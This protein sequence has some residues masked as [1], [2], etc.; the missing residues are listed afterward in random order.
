MPDVTAESLHAL[1]EE[2]IEE[3]VEGLREKLLGLENFAA[4]RYVSSVHLSINEV[5]RFYEDGD[6]VRHDKLTQLCEQLAVFFNDPTTQIPPEQRHQLEAYYSEKNTASPGAMPRELPPLPPLPNLAS[7]PP[8]ANAAEIRQANE[9]A[10]HNVSGGGGGALIPDLNSDDIADGVHDMLA[11][12]D[13]EALSDFEDEV[14]PTRDPAPTP[15]T[16]ATPAPP[17]PEPTPPPTQSSP[18]PELPSGPVTH[19]SVVTMEEE[20]EE[21]KE[22]EEEQ[23]K[24]K[25]KEK[26][27]ESETP[28]RAP[29]PPSSVTEEPVQ[30]MEGAPV[31][32]V[33]EEEDDYKRVFNVPQ[34]QPS[35]TA[36]ADAGAVPL[37]R[38]EPAAGEDIEEISMVSLPGAV[39][40]SNPAG[41]STK[42]LNDNDN[43]GGA[44]APQARKSSRDKK[45]DV[46]APPKAAPQ[47]KPKAQPSSG[48]CCVVA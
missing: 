40:D 1:P 35:V 29:L 17:P 39:P 41:S 25:E 38:G 45:R 3:K 44:G 7:S 47:E 26:E 46:E 28:V 8:F 16:P 34:R 23:K 20:E 48:G 36:D 2:E 31:E 33:A 10:S 12:A 24:E 19:T 43:Q 21:E 37:R 14:S 32:D 4:A 27:K 11:D 9:L 22:K 5:R 15:A 6:P 42:E 30:D 18:P 13:V